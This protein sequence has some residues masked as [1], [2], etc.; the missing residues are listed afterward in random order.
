[1]FGKNK[2]LLKRIRQDDLSAFDEIYKMSQKAVY[3][4]IYVIHPNN[5]ICEDLSQETYLDFLRKKP[6]L[7]KDEDIVPFLVNMAKNKALDLYRRKKKEGVFPEDSEN[8]IG[9]HDALESDLIDKIK[10][11]YDV[12]YGCYPEI[13]QSHF[14]IFGSWVNEK[15]IEVLLGKPRELKCTSYYAARRFIIEEMLRYRNS[16]PYVGGLVLRSTKNIANVPVHH[17]ARMEGK[18]GYS[19]GKLLG[20]WFNGFTAFSVK[21]LRLATVVGFLCAAAGFIYGVVMVLRKLL[22]YTTVLGYSSLITVILFIG[23]I[24]MVLLGIIGEYIGRIYISINNAPQYVIRE[25]IGGS[26]E[27]TD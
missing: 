24:I 8:F 19:L 14:R 10:E 7:K 18:S 12:V 15:M 3:F 11:G 25:T 1:M 5:E 16:Y 2:E 4:A 21:P 17:R 9:T 26:D 27:K 20:L 6:H 23:G 22:G 13:K